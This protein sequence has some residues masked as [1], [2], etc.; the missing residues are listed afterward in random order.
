MVT[1]FILEFFGL[2]AKGLIY[3]DQPLNLVLHLSI[4]LLVKGEIFDNEA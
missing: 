1:H 3:P 2:I 4:V